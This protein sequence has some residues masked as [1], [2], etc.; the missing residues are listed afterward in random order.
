MAEHGLPPTIEEMENLRAEVARLTAIEAAARTYY[1]A[2]Q[3]QCMA[4]AR[5]ENWFENMTRTSLVRQD[6]EDALF[7]SLDPD[8]DAA[9]NEDYW[10]VEAVTRF[11]AGEANG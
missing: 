6:A 1:D 10:A 11:R 3:Q 5:E 2:Y 4:H 8:Y 7:A 9:R